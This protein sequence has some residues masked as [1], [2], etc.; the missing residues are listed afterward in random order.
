MEKLTIFEYAS[1]ESFISFSIKFRFIL[2]ILGFQFDSIITCF[3][4]AKVAVQYICPA[5]RELE[6]V[7]LHEIHQDV[8]S[9]VFEKL[10][11]NDFVA[12][13]PEGRCAIALVRD[14]FF[15]VIPIPEKLGPEFFDEYETEQQHLVKR[16]KPKLTNYEIKLHDLDKHFHNVADFIIPSGQYV[17]TAIILYEPKRNTAGR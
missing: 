14:A 4:D 5:R 10:Y 9:S 17:P 15:L 1:L 13:D 16:L 3:D 7:S 2:S 6:I 11:A 12:G 8:L